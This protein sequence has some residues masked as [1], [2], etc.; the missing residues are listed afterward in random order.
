[1]NVATWDL[2]DQINQS[3]FSYP[4]DVNEMEVVGLEPADC[5]LV[6][7]PR[8]AAC[9]I[10]LECKYWE[11]VELPDFEGRPSDNAMIIGKVVGVHIDESV[12]VDG[13]V[14]IYKLKPL[15]RRGYMDYTV[16]DAFFEIPRPDKG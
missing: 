7:A 3:S 4:P 10:A 15:A 11:T 5:R 16:V 1:M 12:I 2:R 13:R 8:V 14:D 6:K 9:P